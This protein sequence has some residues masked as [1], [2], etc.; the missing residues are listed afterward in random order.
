LR[1]DSELISFNAIKLCAIDDGLYILSELV[2][3]NPASYI[4]QSLWNPDPAALL[5][6]LVL[7]Y[8]NCLTRCL[9]KM[10]PGLGDSV[11]S[12]DLNLI[13]ALGEH[14]EDAEEGALLFC[15]DIT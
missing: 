10:P 7:A 13:R 6:R 11:I 3:N 9:R 2:G 14:I 5:I 8:T 4:D 15:L 1:E 12:A